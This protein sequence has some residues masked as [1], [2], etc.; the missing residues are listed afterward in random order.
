MLKNPAEKT[1]YL[2]FFILR[3]APFSLALNIPVPA[4]Y[5]L[6]KLRSFWTRKKSH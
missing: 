1:A 6:G 4:C 3:S 5:L 2:S